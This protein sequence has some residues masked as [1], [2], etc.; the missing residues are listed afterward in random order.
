M[1]D[2]YSNR[3]SEPLTRQLGSRVDM[4]DHL[5]SLV[6]LS[7]KISG[8][9]GRDERPSV[10][11]GSRGDNSNQLRGDDVRRHRQYDLDGSQFPEVR[12][13]IL[14]CL[15]IARDLCPQDEPWVPV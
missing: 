15:P 14:F 9:R 7:S 11:S 3:G 8:T 6:Y 5:G 1:R 10:A 2:A 12:R 4:N 13:G